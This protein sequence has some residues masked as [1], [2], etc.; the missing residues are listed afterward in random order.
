MKD[1]THRI[2]RR[3]LRAS[4]CLAASKKQPYDPLSYVLNLGSECKLIG[5][6]AAESGREGL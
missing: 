2:K 5:G 1:Q 3:L 6:W 4:R